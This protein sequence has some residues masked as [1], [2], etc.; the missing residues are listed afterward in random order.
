LK[1]RLTIYIGI[2]FIFCLI[3]NAM[4]KKYYIKE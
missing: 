2:F 1:I 3:V 4:F